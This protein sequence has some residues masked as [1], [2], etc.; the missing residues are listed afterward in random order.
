MP[1]LVIWSMREG[2]EAEV[3]PSLPLRTNGPLNV[4]LLVPPTTNSKLLVP[5]GYSIG[6][7][8]EMLLTEA[9]SVALAVSEEESGVKYIGA[10]PRGPEVI[11]LLPTELMPR[12]VV[13]RAG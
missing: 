7:A 10:V 11:G 9:W 2:K 1:R 6:L 3:L 4:M 12:P 5:L 13:P 8:T